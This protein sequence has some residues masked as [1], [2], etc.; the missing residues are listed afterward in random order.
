MALHNIAVLHR[1]LIL[2]F[3]CNCTYIL[4]FSFSDR[5]KVKKAQEDHKNKYKKDK[6]RNDRITN[7]CKKFEKNNIKKCARDK[8]LFVPSLEECITDVS[9]SPQEADERQL[10]CGM[11]KKYQEACGLKFNKCD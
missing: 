6:K 1:I 9:Y 4:I 11:L 10:V 8:N 2:T 7:L 5:D 3:L